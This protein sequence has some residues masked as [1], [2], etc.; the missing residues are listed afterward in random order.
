MFRFCFKINFYLEWHQQISI[1]R[2]AARQ[3]RMF[4]YGIAFAL[5][6]ELL[7]VNEKNSKIYEKCKNEF[8][9]LYLKAK[10]KKYF[11]IFNFLI[12]IFR[13]ELGIY[14]ILA[15]MIKLSFKE[16]V[17]QKKSAEEW[18]PPHDITVSYLNYTKIIFLGLFACSSFNEYFRVF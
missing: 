6:Y 2:Q 9:K 7:P 4:S 1:H 10:E 18:F 3:V 8:L 13:Q 14:K 12:F 11:L 5:V 15:A 16:D 17:W